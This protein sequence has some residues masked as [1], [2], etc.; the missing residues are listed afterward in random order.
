M[1]YFA[2][3]LND[4]IYGIGETKKAACEDA[5]AWVDTHGGDSDEDLIEMYI[6]P[7]TKTL[8]DHVV[9]YGG[10]SIPTER[11]AGGLLDYDPYW[12]L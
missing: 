9:Q 5:C 2:A 11:V 3:I 4:Q 1:T 7:I 12:N 10:G 6:E 8:Y